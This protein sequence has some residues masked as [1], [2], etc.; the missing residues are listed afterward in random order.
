[1]EL[2]PGDRGK[3]V[4]RL[5]RWL[6]SYLIG[7]GFLPCCRRAKLFKNY[8]FIGMWGM[9]QGGELSLLSGVD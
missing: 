1:M 3:S 7:D 9:P 5:C 4:F 2:K 6:G 8:S